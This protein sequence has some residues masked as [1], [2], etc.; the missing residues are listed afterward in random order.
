MARDPRYLRRSISIE[1]LVYVDNRQIPCA[2][3][4]V[5]HRDLLLMGPSRLGVGKYV[6]V[7]LYLPRGEII[8]VE[9][10]VIGE[11]ETGG[12]SAWQVRIA[13]IEPQASEV[14]ADFARRAR[15]AGVRA[16]TPQG[17][18]GRMPVDPVPPSK[19]VSGTTLA[20]WSAA[21]PASPPEPKKRRTQQGLFDAESMRPSEPRPSFPPAG[22]ACHEPCRPRTGE[23][24]RPC[25]MERRRASHSSNASSPGSRPHL[26]A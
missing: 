24:S 2:A 8:D 3:L 19:E 11:T 26:R 16:S 25:A 23:V 17:P 10:L 9:G 21:G 6:R 12:R 22:P 13:Q 4:G 1:A 14:L 18:K 7:H 5:D 20:G 15:P